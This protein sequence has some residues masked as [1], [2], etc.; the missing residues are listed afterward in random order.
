MFNCFWRIKAWP[1]AHVTAWRVMK[2]KIVVKVNL[3]RREIAVGSAP[4]CFC[5]VKGEELNHLDCGG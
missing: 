4:C 3:L 5:K 1:F 2:N